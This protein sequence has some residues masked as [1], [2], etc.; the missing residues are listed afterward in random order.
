M[1]RGGWQVRVW[2]MA[3]GAAGLAV[4]AILFA[5]T[6]ETGPAALAGFGTALLLL[7]FARVGEPGTPDECA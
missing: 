3:I 6:G 4:S 1:K 7:L 2:Y 5:M